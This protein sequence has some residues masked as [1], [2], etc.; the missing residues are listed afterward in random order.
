MLCR[1][2]RAATAIVRRSNGARCRLGRWTHASI[3]D[4]ALFTAPPWY[5]QSRPS[6][7]A[8]ILLSYL[9]SRCRAY[10][11]NGTFCLQPDFRKFTSLLE[12][13]IIVRLRNHCIE[14]IADHR[15]K[16][17][18][19]SSLTPIILSIARYDATIYG[20]STKAKHHSFLPTSSW[21]CMGI[22]SSESPQLKVNAS[23]SR[24][25][26]GDPRIRRTAHNQTLT[27]ARRL[28]RPNI[29]QVAV[30]SS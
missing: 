12:K 3:A 19:C 25:T 29:K 21:K 10:S 2:I 5:V 22:E 7:V 15:H 17:T 18:A 30:C 8:D 20:H 1:A 11:H 16:R 14:V 13:R 6:C 9:H 23:G 26:I 27:T 28:C 4:A 24:V